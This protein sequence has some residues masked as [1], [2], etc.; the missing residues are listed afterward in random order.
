MAHKVT[1][2]N[3]IGKSRVLE[4]TGN[5]DFVNL[6]NLRAYFRT[7][8]EYQLKNWWR[9]VLVLACSRWTGISLVGNPQAMAAVIY[10]WR[11]SIPRF[12]ET[13]WAY[14]LRFGLIYAH[15]DRVA[16][17]DLRRTK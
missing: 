8:L 12:R 4:I 7:R 10:H 13:V 15:L 2:E 5:R 16:L 17:L 9:S 6:E 11:M 1:P 3:D 14:T